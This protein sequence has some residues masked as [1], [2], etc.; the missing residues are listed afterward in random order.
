M[1]YHKLKSA[2]AREVDLLLEVLE[3]IHKEEERLMKVAKNKSGSA[4][5]GHR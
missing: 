5:K 4:P 2:P 3:E 1:D